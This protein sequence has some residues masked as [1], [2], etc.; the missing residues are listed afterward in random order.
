MNPTD[1]LHDLK[2]LVL[3]LHPVIAVETREEER[4]EHLVQS[5]A[6]ELGHEVFEWSFTQG[7][8]RW[9]DR[10]P[11]ATWRDAAAMLGHLRGLTVEALFLLKDLTRH[12]ED[13]GVARCFADVARQ[14]A[15]TRST[16]IVVG[17]ALSFPKEI[18]HLVVHFDLALPDKKELRAVID[19]VLASLR[20]RKPVEMELDDAA[21]EELLRALSGLTLN[22]ARQAIARAVIEDGALTPSDVQV[23]IDAKAQALATEGVLEYLPASD[24]GY[25]L[26]GFGRLK[27]WLDRARVGFS[28]E[29]R[30]LNLQAPR[31]ILLVGVQGC[32]KSL[33]AKSTAGAWRLPLLKLDAGRLYDKY[34]GETEKNLRRALE[35]AES[36]APVV[37][38]ID[39]LEKSLSSGGELDGGV[40]K[41]VL[42]TFLTWL[43][44]KRQEVFVVATANDVFALPP[45]LLRKGRFD[46]IFFVDLPDSAE[47]QEI[48][49]IHLTHRKQDPTR[50][51]VAYLADAT[52]GWSGAELEQAVTAALYGSLHKKRPLDTTLLLQEIGATVPLS[53]SRRED[54]ERLR[55]LGRE[56]FV[57][58][59]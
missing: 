19:S 44:E 13:P 12:L 2:T 45:E 47:R 16:M 59:R 18:E 9:P 30:A 46:E 8:V 50:F 41:R 6:L 49:R 51:D 58:V 42:A 53:V 21:M 34:V 17:A 1:S 33:A 40:S 3:S 32:G 55:A 31:G 7:L 38:W 22:Q 52:E 43:Q 56:R 28:E 26:G 5:L 48:L 36:M 57:P 24:N 23:I 4:V 37:L 11:N 54:V 39:E 10:T 27:S 29:A 14:F 15:R 25:Q 20:E 35:I